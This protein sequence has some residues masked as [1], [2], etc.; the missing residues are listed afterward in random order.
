[1]LYCERLKC[2]RKERSLNQEDVAKILG[3]TKQAYGRYENGTRKL[4][5]DDLVKLCKFYDVSSDYIIGI[6]DT[7]KN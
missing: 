7:P 4:S 5:I 6:V 1:M 3:I 2:L